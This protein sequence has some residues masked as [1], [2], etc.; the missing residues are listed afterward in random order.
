[1]L[2]ILRAAFNEA[3]HAKLVASHLGTHHTE[4]YVSASEAREVI[5]K[6]S[7][8]YDEPFADSSQIPTRLVSQLA[9]SK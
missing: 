7:S 4:L 2:E 8:I 3:N 5:P 6:L 9:R 1:M